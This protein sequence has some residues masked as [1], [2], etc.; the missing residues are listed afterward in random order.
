M[1]QLLIVEDDQLL[2]QGITFALRKAGY[3]TISA[4][5]YSEGFQLYQQYPSIGLILLDVNLPDGSGIELCSLIRSNSE[6]PIIMLTA[7]DTEQDMILGF[8]TGCDDYMAKPFSIEV[9]KQRIQAV[10]RRLK[11][12]GAPANLFTSGALMIDYDKMAVTKSGE[13]VHLTATEY[14]LL[15]LL[16]RCKGQVLTREMIVEKLWDIDGNFVEPNALSVN[17]RR[18]RQKIEED[19][20]HPCYVRTVFGIGYTWGEEA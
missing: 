13:P 8:Q 16:T 14:K 1:I 10:L 4:F 17:I 9:L 5:T 19:P 3:E 18:L 2:N 12:D 7:N 6:V 20:K 15:E 11:K